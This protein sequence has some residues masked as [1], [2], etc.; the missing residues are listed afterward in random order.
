MEWMLNKLDS[1]QEEMGINQEKIDANQQRMEAKQMLIVRS[2]GP[3]R[4]E[5]IYIYICT[6]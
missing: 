1:Y 6:C 3:L 5:Y 2:R 4:N